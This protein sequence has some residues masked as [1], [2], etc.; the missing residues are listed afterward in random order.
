MPYEL[1]L[2][3]QCLWAFL[4]SLGFG[5]FFN[6]RGK[7]LWFAALAGLVGWVAYLVSA[8]ILPGAVPQSFWAGTAISLYSEC[9]A[10]RRKC[11]V[12]VFLVA[13]M[14]PLVPG[15]T[16]YYTMEALLLGDMR[17]FVQM[18]LSTFE[19]AGAIAM[20]ILS[21]S[22]LVRLLKSLLRRVRCRERRTQ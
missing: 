4:G 16:I 13:A 7:N 19:V 5:I 17:R 14:I 9:M 18:G 10:V 8:G 20:G 15:S 6:I 2:V 12:T 22:F 11:P 3:L 21:V 1:T